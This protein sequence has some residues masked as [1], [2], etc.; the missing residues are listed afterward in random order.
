MFSKT[1]HPLRWMEASEFL[2]EMPNQMSSIPRIKRRHR[3]GYAD[4]DY[5]LFKPIDV[6]AFILGN[7]PVTVL[8][9]RK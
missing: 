8:G 7:D 2:Q 4:G 3:D 5:T 9:K 1:L 6:S